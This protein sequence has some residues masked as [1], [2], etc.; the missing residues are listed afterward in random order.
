MTAELTRAPMPRL[1]SMSRE[2]KRVAMILAL[3]C[4]FAS[5]RVMANPSVRR[6]VAQFIYFYQQ[7]GD[8]HAD[9]NLWERVVFSCLL[10]KTTGY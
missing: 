4:G 5:V 8:I 7:N 1:I 10:T 3:A 6:P 9:M 2:W